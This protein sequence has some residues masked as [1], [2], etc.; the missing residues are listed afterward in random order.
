MQ[1]FSNF[2]NSLVGIQ[3]LSV[4][5]LPVIPTFFIV[6]PVIAAITK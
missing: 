4:S 1:T 3:I 2:L 6:K 5:S